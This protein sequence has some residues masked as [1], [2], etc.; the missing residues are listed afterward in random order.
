MK[1]FASLLSLLIL[2]SLSAFAQDSTGR[3]T[4]VVKDSVTNEPVVGAYVAVSRNL[5]DAK[6]EYVTTD[7]EGKF[8][9]NGLAKQAVYL[10]KVS[11]L[12]YKD[13]SRTVTLQD[14]NQDVG[15]FQLSEAVA[16]LKEIKV[17]GQV[18]A[19]EQK[20]DTTQFNAAA[21]KT[22]PDATSEDLIQ[23]MPG[24]T[25]TNGTVTAHGETVNRVLVDGKPF[26]GEDAALTLKSL[27]AEIVDKIEVFDKLS[28]Q[29]QFTGFDDGNGQ[30]T[31]NIVTKAD[32]KMGQFGKVFAG[33]G[34]DNRYQA[35]GNVSFF[36]GNQRISVIGL[37]NNINMQNFSSQ[38]LIGVSG[39]GGGGGRGGSGGGGSAGNFLVGN[40]SGITGTN[41][42]GLNYAN[43]FG[44]KVDVTGSYF[45]NRTGNTNAQT[46]EQEYFLQGGTG[47]QFYN[48]TSRTNNTNANH[49]L[50]FRIEYNI[51]KNNSLIVTPRLSFQD[52]SS[53]SVK[54]GLSSL[55]NGTKINSL[56]NNQRN[57]TNAYNFNNDVL[58][59]HSFEKKGR[60]LSVNLN[61]QLN[62]RN[63]IGNLYSRTMFY[64][65][66]GLAARG[67]TLDQESF[68]YSNG[69]TLGGNLIY[70]EPIGKNS[71]LQ[72]NYGLTVSNSDSKKE[73]YNMSFDENTYSGLDSLLSNTFDNRYVTNRA[74][75]GYRYRKNS[76]SANFGL[77][78]QNTGLYSQQLAP[79]NAKVDQSFTN[80][81]PNFMLSYRSKTGTQFRTFFR[82]STNQ[83][84][85]SQL[86]NVIDNSNPLALTAGNPDLKQE[87]RNM[88]NVRYSLAGAERPYS[89]N[90][91][92]FV[93]QT[94]NAIV[95]STLIA[96]E[97]TEVADGIVLER[98]AKFTKPV[99]VDGSWNARTFLAY[100]K[101]VAPLKL[102]VNLTTGFNY[103]R[104]PGLINNISNYSN[105]YAVSQGLVVSSNVSEKLDF[106]V[107]YSGN[108]NIVRNTIQPNLNN[109]YYTQGITGRVN[110]I[111]G[112]GFVVQS[113]ISNQSYRGLGQG[114]NQNFT[115]WNASVG[116]KFLKNNAGELKLTVFDILKQNNSITRNVTETYVQDVTNRVLTQYAMLTFTYTLRNFGKAPAPE[117]NR[118][119]DFEGGDMPGGGR[120]NR[121]DR[122]N[123]N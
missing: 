66:L 54:A 11:Y 28:D 88:F 117:N 80:L 48:E 47:N 17:V 113:D 41:S 67:D 91:M 86:Q 60:T 100:G 10:V 82:S 39:G 107:S 53:A 102:N 32:R 6:P 79:V 90:A 46:L 35:G 43:K 23:K 18:T 61:T 78:F 98:G 57:A 68:T 42:F 2:L 94:N 30:K 71:Q 5:P 4:G 92:V 75:I 81:L 36:K 8:S 104:S 108:Y 65:S 40:Q 84:S 73:T 14:D 109:N 97:P 33:Y 12:S 110:W 51:N 103:V 34:L 27:P 3:I 87:Y 70:T 15:T 49:R 95:N 25:V 72:F 116:K 38:D 31:I 93:T 55:I 115:L 58:F 64:D 123:F 16:N 119:R 77:D 101:P 1:K 52:N 85:I 114:F 74:G 19:M 26:F 122:G 96:Q 44:K 20:G 83:P 9:F 121:G 24:I 45:F 120:G 13:A 99:N 106:T 59:R 22:N 111:F 69:V 118:R 56:D 62:D 37:S 112:K 29:A 76:W 105:T 89:L 50:N 7:I 21:F 63:G